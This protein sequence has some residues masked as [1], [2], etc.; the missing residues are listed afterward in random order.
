LAGPNGLEIGRA[1]V[2]PLDAGAVYEAS[3]LWDTAALPYR[4]AFLPVWAVADPQ[5]VV[6]EWDETNNTYSQSVHVAPAWAP[7][8]TQA[9]LT[10]NGGLRLSFEAADAAPGNF[11][12]ESAPSL[13]P[14][15]V[16]TPETGVVVQMPEAG[17]FQVDLPRPEQTRFYRVRTQP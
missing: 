12:L 13:L 1:V 9:R 11:V 2:P 10:E 16:W 15:P 8:F 14:S 7:R 17:H 5:G 4:D 6:E 3:G